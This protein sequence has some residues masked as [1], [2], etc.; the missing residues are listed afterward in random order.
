MDINSQIEKQTA[1][2]QATAAYTC[3]GLHTVS[4]YGMDVWDRAFAL[5]Q[6]GNPPS[7]WAGKDGLPTLR[8]WHNAV[9]RIDSFAM[10]LKD[11]PLYVP[12]K[13]RNPVL[14]DTMW[15]KVLARFGAG[16]SKQDICTGGDWPTAKQWN[17]KMKRDASFR[18]QINEEWNRRSQA[19]DAEV[20][21]AFE[22]WRS[23]RLTLL[24]ATKSPAV[25]QR[26]YVRMSKDK[27]FAK[28]VNAIWAER[29]PS[30]RAVE[31]L[32][33]NAL[34][35]VKSGGLL[36]NLPANA[37]TQ[38]MIAYRRGMDPDFAALWWSSLPERKAQ[39]DLSLDWDGLLDAVKQGHSIARHVG[40]DNRPTQ[41]QWNYR[42]R[43]DKAFAQA[44]DEALE[45]GK[46]T[47]AQAADKALEL[48]KATRA[49]AK[50]KRSRNSKQHAQQIG[51]AFM[52]QLAQNDLY[53]AINAAVPV[54]LRP[55]P[56]YARRHNQRHDA[57]GAGGRTI[58]R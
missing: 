33:S 9:H 41:S 47:R 45:L 28:K 46:A 22:L 20:D 15:Q 27:A 13:S 29:R 1:T 8:Q 52:R 57:R 51:E 7:Q 3:C 44:A 31:Q 10:R 54:A 49:Q 21:A 17:A 26:W 48:G 14:Q 4:G 32:F 30:R 43:K 25:M 37:A 35:H 42:R 34:D 6:A 56:T 58:D 53:A 40:K 12:R 38:G 16:E 50:A 19:A 55:P 36:K 23:S 39:F 11:S 18:Q 24:E 5:W 2:C